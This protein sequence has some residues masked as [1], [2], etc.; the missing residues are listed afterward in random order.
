MTPD[1]FKMI[2]DAYIRKKTCMYT[3]DDAMLDSA[4][5]R[6]AIPGRPSSLPLTDEV[7]KAIDQQMGNDP[8]SILFLE[9]PYA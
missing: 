9:T 2:F 8:K 7:R 3:C 4:E 1:C 6:A 5:L